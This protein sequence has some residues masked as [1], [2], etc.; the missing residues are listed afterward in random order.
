MSRRKFTELFKNG[1]RQ[2]NY[3]ILGL[4]I[5]SATSAIA[6]FDLNQSAPEIID[7][8]GGYGKPSVPTVMQY[9]ADTKEWVFGEYAMAN[10]SGSKDITI[11]SL[12]QKLGLGEYVDVSGKPVSVTSILG[13]YIKELVGN[14]K[15]INPKAEIAGIAVSVPAYL[16]KEAEAELSAVLKSAG[17]EKP[18]LG[19]LDDRECVLNRFYF[20]RAIK[21]ETVMIIDFGARELRAGVYDICPEDDGNVSV[22]CR[23]FLFDKSLGT[24]I[25]DEVVSQMFQNI[26][27]GHFNIPPER[28]DQRQRE[29]L[30]IFSYQ[31]KDLLFRKDIKS[32]PLKIYYNFAYPPFQASISHDMAQEI[33]GPLKECVEAF[34]MEARK[35]SDGKR[36][37]IK[38]ISSV[39]CVGGGFEMLWAR[40]VVSEAFPESEIAIYKNPKGVTAEGASVAAATE[41]CAFSGKKFLIKDKNRIDYD[42]GFKILRDNRERFTPIVESSTFWWQTH[43]PKQFI[44]TE[45]TSPA[46]HIQMFK[47]DKSGTMTPIKSLALDGLPDRPAGVTRLSISIGFSGSN[48]I[49]AKV[50][51]L[52][53]GELFPSSDY[54]REFVFDTESIV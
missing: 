28:L 4:D 16:G 22:D 31:H 18:L 49:K 6:Y 40:E 30:E 9:V 26:Y 24:D 10:R 17:Y 46:A 11:L 54:E 42:I 13:L 14:C 36:I 3:F 20:D 33:V 34:L 23:S 38:D 21:K 39:I 2:E 32:K 53:F 25:V 50:R 47:R 37:D 41:L 45:P 44:L 8:S 43:P 52:G 29:Q 27:C 48:V 19:F 1:I 12:V 5:G 7:I 51:D 15:N 35:T